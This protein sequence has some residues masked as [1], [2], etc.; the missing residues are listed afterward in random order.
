[1]RSPK[2]DPPKVAFRKKFGNS[3]TKS[4]INRLCPALTGGPEKGSFSS[5]HIAKLQN[6]LESLKNG[7]TSDS[8]LFANAPKSLDIIKIHNPSFTPGCNPEVPKLTDYLFTF[9]LQLKGEIKGE[10]AVSLAD[11]VAT[12]L[13]ANLQEIIGEDKYV[14][15]SVS[16]AFNRIEKIAGQP[17]TI[18][19]VGFLI[20]RAH[21]VVMRNK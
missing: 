21:F 4:I 8:L 12:M 5:R 19:D 17:A 9:E 15:I 11:D 6:E 7:L 13:L 10:D 3:Y 16:V 20:E 2:M 14:D 18:I 1:M